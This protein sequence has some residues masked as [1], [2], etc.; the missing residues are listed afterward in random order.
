[1]LGGIQSEFLCSAPSYLDEVSL[2]LRL[3]CRP[4]LIAYGIVLF[5]IASLG[6]VFLAACLV[7]ADPLTLP[8]VVITFRMCHVVFQ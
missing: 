5:T 7:S 3:R 8:M 6:G 1:M 2:V 4:Y